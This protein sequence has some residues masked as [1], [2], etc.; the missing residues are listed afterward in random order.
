MSSRIEQGPTAVLWRQIID[1][2]DPTNPDSL[3]TEARKRF[4]G[5][6]VRPLSNNSPA[7]AGVDLE[8]NFY[9][10]VALSAH[11]TAHE[12]VHMAQINLLSP[13]EKRAYKLAAKCLAMPNLIRGMASWLIKQTQSKE[14]YQ[15]VKDILQAIRIK[16][17]FEMVIGLGIDE[18]LTVDDCKLY[19]RENMRILSDGI[20]Q[21]LNRM[22]QREVEA[23]TLTLENERFFNT[24]SKELQTDQAGLQLYKLLTGWISEE[25]QTRRRTIIKSA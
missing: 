7:G 21:H 16:S 17:E 9:K 15:D 12:L 20:L 2:S 24:T 18:K 25:E 5:M 22:C 19:I 11:F 8:G 1:K 10:S 14:Q 4:P 3:L 23:Y 13:R 6:K